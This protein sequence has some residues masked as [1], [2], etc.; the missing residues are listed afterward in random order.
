LSFA[1]STR[2]HQKLQLRRRLIRTARVSRHFR[3]FEQLLRRILRRLLE[4]LIRHLK[5][6]AATATLL[7]IQADG[8]PIDLPKRRFFLFD[9]KK[10][11]GVASV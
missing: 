4:M 1:A 7:P 6:S 2:K 3:R 10:E 8:P 5:G 9:P 11:A